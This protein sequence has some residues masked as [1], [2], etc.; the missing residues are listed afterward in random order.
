MGRLVL[1]EYAAALI[2][3]ASGL[4]AEI[5]PVK[6]RLVEQR[7]ELFV[8]P[9]RSR[10]FT[11]RTNVIVVAVDCDTWIEITPSNGTEYDM[12]AGE[13]QV[14]RVAPGA[15]LTATEVFLTSSNETEMEI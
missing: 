4:L 11:A 1:N 2:E 9:M 15:Q 8:G 13:E 5:D 7:M 3:S 6:D 12:A 14:I 10:P